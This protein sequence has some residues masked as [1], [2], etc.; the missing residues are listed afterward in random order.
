[1]LRRQSHSPGAVT[2]SMEIET[3]LDFIGAQQK[4]CISVCICMCVCVCIYIHTY[5]YAYTYTHI[6]LST[7]KSSSFYRYYR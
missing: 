3:L 2:H 4:V 7:N 5:T 1:M 6:L